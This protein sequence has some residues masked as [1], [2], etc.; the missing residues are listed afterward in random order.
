MVEHVVRIH[1][2]LQHMLPVDIELMFG[3]QP[4]LL[5]ARQRVTIGQTVVIGLES[6][7]CGVFSA[8]PITGASNRGTVMPGPTITPIGTNSPIMTLVRIGSRATIIWDPTAATVR[9]RAAMI[10]TSSWT[11]GRR[12]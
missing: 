2:E 8:V 3:N 5:P 12:N 1:H 10:L 7:A 9:T 6:L 11:T 4:P